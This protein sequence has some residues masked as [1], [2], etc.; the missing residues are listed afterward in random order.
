VF[1]LILVALRKKVPVG[2]TLFGAGLLTAIFYWVPLTDLASGYWDL[3]RSRRFLSLTGAICFIT[4]LGVLLRESG[5]LRKLTDACSG[6]WGG[7]RTATVL[8]PPLVGMMPMPGGALMSAPLIDRVL[9]DPEYRPEFKCAVNYYF[10]HVIEHFWPIYPGII[11]T[12]AITGLPAATVAL[13]QSP[14]AAIMLTLGLIFFVRRIR[15]R[16]ID[17]RGFFASLIGIIAA[18]WPIG[19]AVIIYGVFKIEL[20]LAILAAIAIV[21]VIA[22]PPGRAIKEAVQRGLSYKLIFLVFGIL[23]FQTALELSGA[24]A[25]LQE[26]T[27]AYGLPPQLVIIVVA[28]TAGML[29]GMFAAYVALAYSL[30]AGFLYLPEIVPANIFL[31]FLSGYVGMML[32][33]AHVCLVVTNE[34]FKSDLIKV[35]RLLVIPLLLLA[36]A[37]YLVFLSPWPGW[38]YP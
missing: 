11:V 22:R 18:I 34:Y 17:R 37:G 33:P 8:L 25:L 12:E 30:L 28:F 19:I 14:L 4:M 35:L 13:L 21:I 23:S 29:T 5:F 24:V 9:D 2:V 38:V 16:N 1:I 26:A 36:V 7:R 3:I 15:L 27:I 32:S 10:R 20:A 6:L 31:A